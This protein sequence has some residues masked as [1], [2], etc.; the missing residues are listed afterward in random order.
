MA[1]FSITPLIIADTGDGAA[2]CASGSQ[3]WSGTRPAL[4]PKPASASRKAADAQAGESSCA[5]MPAKL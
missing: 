1:V 4:A 2:G 3:T 5:R